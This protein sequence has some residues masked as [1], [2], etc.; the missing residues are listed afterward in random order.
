M[1]WKICTRVGMSFTER[2]CEVGQLNVVATHLEIPE[3]AR[4]ALDCEEP[5]EWKQN[6]TQ[7]DRAGDIPISHQP[8]EKRCRRA[9]Q[10]EPRPVISRH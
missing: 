9:S 6:D 10:R 1:I 2:A 5:D 7:R 8:V 3:A 4:D